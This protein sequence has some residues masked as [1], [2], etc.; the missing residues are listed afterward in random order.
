MDEFG[1]ATEKP[2]NVIQYKSGTKCFRV[3]PIKGGI[4]TEYF[5]NGKP[6]TPEQ[7]EIARRNK[8]GNQNRKPTDVSL[9]NIGLKNIKKIVAD[10]QQLL[11]K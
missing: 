2:S 6:A 8:S 3:Y 11:F 5:V 10:N 7:I 9:M 4:K 1:N